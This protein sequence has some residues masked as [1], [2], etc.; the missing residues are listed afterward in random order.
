MVANAIERTADSNLNDTRE[1]TLHNLQER[2]AKS[3]KR[4]RDDGAKRV[5][6]HRATKKVKLEEQLKERTDERKNRDYL[7]TGAKWHDERM[8]DLLTRE[9]TID[10]P[11]VPENLKKQFQ[12]KDFDNPEMKEFLENKEM[13]NHEKVDLML[14][15]I[16]FD[17]N[18]G[19]P[20][21]PIHD[22]YCVKHPFNGYN[23]GR[24]E[25]FTSRTCRLV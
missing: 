1:K 17:C 6:E 21:W 4:K 2:K 10:L 5:R 16:E 9:I 22:R 3:A 13:T 20:I 7:E 24:S 19:A 25:R 15:N 11:G 8:Q 12:W 23:Q 14:R 18:R